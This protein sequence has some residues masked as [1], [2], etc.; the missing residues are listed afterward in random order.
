ML[1]RVE[2]QHHYRYRDSADVKSATVGNNFKLIEVV[3]KM[4]NRENNLLPNLRQIHDRLFG[5]TT[6]MQPQIERIQAQGISGMMP[7]SGEYSDIS[8]FGDLP[9]AAVTTID[10]YV[11]MVRRRE[12]AKMRKANATSTISTPSDN[13]ST[14]NSS[15]YVDISWKDIPTKTYTLFDKH[16]K[17]INAAIAA[18][19]KEIDE[20]PKYTKFYIWLYKWMT[21]GWETNKRRIH[22]CVTHTTPEFLNVKLF[23]P[24]PVPDLYL[25]FF[26]YHWNMER[27]FKEQDA[28][29]PYTGIPP[30]TIA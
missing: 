25:D 18:F 10:D 27:V 8:E 3:E 1:E 5:Q 13:N 26:V 21:A 11:N 16:D 22:A 2:Q 29:E 28:V 15:E 30:P 9:H 7:S 6:P 20:K 24:F 23:T 19:K 14:S 12:K 17:V 4:R